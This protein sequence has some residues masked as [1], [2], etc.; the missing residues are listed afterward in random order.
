MT[1]SLPDG[2]GSSRS[3]RIAARVRPCSQKKADAFGTSCGSG[4]VGCRAHLRA[5]VQLW[6]PCG[7]MITNGLSVSSAAIGAGAMRGGLRASLTAGAKWGTGGVTW[8]TAGIT[9]YG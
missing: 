3:A 2:P 7:T 4:G 1:P 8:G 5:C 9:G 6:K